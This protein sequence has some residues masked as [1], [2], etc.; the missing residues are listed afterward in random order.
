[1]R[2]DGPSHRD[3]ADKGSHL[4]PQS[5][6][7]PDAA[8][9]PRPLGSLELTRA[10][11]LRRRLDFSPLLQIGLRTA[12]SPAARGPDVRRSN[13]AARVRGPLAPFADRCAQLDPV[14]PA[15]AR[16]GMLFCRAP[17]S[18]PVARTPFSLS[19]ALLG[20]KGIPSRAIGR[21]HF[22]APALSGRRYRAQIRKK[23]KSCRKHHPLPR[24]R[25]APPQQNGTFLNGKPLISKHIA[26]KLY[27]WPPVCGPEWILTPLWVLHCRPQSGRSGPRASVDRSRWSNGARAVD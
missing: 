9:P 23:G 22:F 11:V 24:T 7:L 10:A 1:L 6:R 19:P 12:P 14:D 3:V 21:T 20:R 4:D 5:R 13:A 15:G 17:A 2:A 8:L 18:L 16:G 26:G 27:P 25:R